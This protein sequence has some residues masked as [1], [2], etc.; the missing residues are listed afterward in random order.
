MQKIAVLLV[1]PQPSLPRLV[2]FGELL[3]GT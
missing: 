1:N 3:P 2:I